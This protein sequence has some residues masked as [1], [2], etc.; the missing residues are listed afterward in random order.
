MSAQ[1]HRQVEHRIDIAVPAATVYRLIADVANWPLLFPPTVHAEQLERTGDEE[2][3]RI[4]ASANGEPKSWTSRRRLDEPGRRIE[5]RQEVSAPPVAAM[6]GTWLIEPDG[7]AACRV[8]LGHD[9]RAVGDDPEHLAW[10]D[11]AVDRNSTAELAALKENAEIAGGAS[12]RLLSFADTVAIDAPAKD[13]YDFLNEAD[14]WAERLPHVAEVTLT[15][16]TPGL[17]ELAMRTRAKDGSTHV[18]RSFRVCFAPERIVYKQT[19]LPALMT[20]HT[21][22]W[23][24]EPQVRGVSVTSRHTVVINEAAI[25]GVLGPDAGP[26]EAAD[27]VRTA[28]STN[29]RA[30]LQHA[31][32]HAERRG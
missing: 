23:L 15:E 12:G 28:L 1:P 27:Y 8:R 26:A 19:Q 30:T 13:V 10:I 3:I 9:Y 21:G 16:D 31:K 5:F 6:A 2:R 14:R 25:A 32:N 20:L 11:R 29:S 22:E 24:I 4:W 18:T 17:Q 7:A